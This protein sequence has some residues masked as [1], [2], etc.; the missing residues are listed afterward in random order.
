[1]PNKV[2]Y[3]NPKGAPAAQGLYSHVSGLEGGSTIYIAGQV[4]A[5]ADG[6]TS[7]KFGD[8]VRQVYKNLGDVLKGA[9]CD[10]N[11]VLKFTTY[12]VGS[13]NI[14][15]YMTERAVLFPK[16]FKGDLYPPN[17]L[18]IIDRLV[19]PEF[20]IEVEAIVAAP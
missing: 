7:K 15:V 10:Y 17:T 14:K 16:L 20:L 2:W 9:G 4:G 12:I 18:L 19:K 11:S 13:R 1:M 8:Q 6:K 5:G 3:K